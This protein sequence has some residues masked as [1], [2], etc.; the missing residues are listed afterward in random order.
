MA[1]EVAGRLSNAEVRAARA[2]GGIV[3]KVAGSSAAIFGG[4]FA[5]TTV[6]PHT[7][8][9]NMAKEHQLLPSHSLVPTLDFKVPPQPEFHEALFDALTA[10]HLGQDVHVGCMGGSGRTGVFIAVL[11][12]AISEAETGITTNGV[13]VK[14]CR[15]LYQPH[16]VETAE[17][18]KFVEGYNVAPLV[19]CIEM[20]EE[21]R[22]LIEAG[23]TAVPAP[24]TLWG[25]IRKF[26]R[27]L[28]SGG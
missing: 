8:L 21:M 2:K 11:L 7:W 24:K 16:A 1:T 12:A 18:Q 20:L 6:N 22:G 19:R 27:G 23:S 13:R 25:R 26:F 28:R 15:S 14:N 9:V 10:L 4:P 3:V 17:Q 5:D